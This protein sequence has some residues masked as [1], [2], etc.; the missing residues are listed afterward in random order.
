LGSTSSSA[1]YMPAVAFDGNNFLVTWMDL[2]SGPLVKGA[3][4]RASDGVV[5]DT[6]PLRISPPDHPGRRADG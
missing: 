5:L 2:N 3:R 4:V 1:D 6:P